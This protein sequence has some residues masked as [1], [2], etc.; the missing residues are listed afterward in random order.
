MRIIIDCYQYQ[1]FVTGTDRQARHF[2]EELQRIDTKNYYELLCSEHTFIPSIV[3]APNFHIIRPPALPLPIYVSRVIVKVWRELLYLRLSLKNAD[4]YFSFHNMQL[5]RLR[6]ARRMI[7]SN[8]DLIPIVLPDYF[9]IGRHSKDKNARRYKKNSQNADAI[10]SISEYSKG[11]LHRLFKIPEKKISVIP[12]AA[13]LPKPEIKYMSIN[14]KPVPR[15]FILTIG[16][17]EA[18]KNVDAVMRAHTKLSQSHQREYPLVVVGGD[19]QGKR[20]QEQD[21]CILL[22]RVS[23][24]E[25][26]YLYKKATL[27][28]FASSY[29][30]FGL[31]LLEALSAGTPS[32]SSRG[33]SLDELCTGI[34]AQF[35]PADTL[36]L[37]S[38]MRRLLENN[39]LQKQYS[40]MAKN[41]AEAYSWKK[42]ARL[43]HNL[44]TNDGIPL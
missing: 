31:P 38:L 1:P 37:S 42:S 35:N 12:L 39:Q 32:V 6:V 23:D 30:G 25:L 3:K 16:G 36:E 44:L 2:I 18:R 27:F 17:A 20:L 24:E 41:V 43:L 15:H 10:M 5:P 8:L 13:Q 7:M 14:S 28:V 29:E 21:N 22:D 33:T 4:V 11:E 19:W 9:K 40:L 34:I 26:S